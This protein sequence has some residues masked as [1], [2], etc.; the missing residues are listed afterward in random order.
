MKAEAVA[1]TKTVSEPA[2]KMNRLR[3]YLQ[4]F[5]LRSLHES[6][7]FQCLSF[8][9]GTALRIVFGLPRFSEDLD[10]SLES[11]ADY[12]PVQWMGKLKRDLHF[13]GFE[14]SVTWNDRKPVHTAWVKVS[15]IMHE[16]GISPLPSQKLSIKIEIDSNPPSGAQLE[17]RIL[18]APF[19]YAVRH[20]DLSSLMA[21][22]LHA[23]STRKYL[24]GRDWYDLLWYLTQRPP[25]EPNLILLQNALEQTLADNAWA[26][27]DWRNQ[28]SQRA[29]R[30]NV[31]LMIDDVAP[32]LE[33]PQETALLTRENFLKILAET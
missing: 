20:N 16:A 23:L 21:G 7:A 15:E 5:V 6:K 11:S 30:M 26:S 27:A 14:P 28:V 18:N 24:K 31:D 9:G 3:E 29:R 33:R 4:A 25:V 17:N 8:V 10:F 13:A 1:V 2:E 22:K 12:K 19:L 32:F